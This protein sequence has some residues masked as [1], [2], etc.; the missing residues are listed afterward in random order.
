MPC[1]VEKENQSKKNIQGV[2]FIQGALYVDK[3]RRQKITIYNNIQQNRFR[4]LVGQM[5][6]NKTDQTSNATYER[7]GVDEGKYL[8]GLYVSRGA[9]YTDNS[10]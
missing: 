9:L 1:G 3:Y 6:K 8:G 4:K 5:I 7:S 10:I 2:L